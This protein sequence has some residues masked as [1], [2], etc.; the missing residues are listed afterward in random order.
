[1]IISEN[2]LREW[3]DLD[4]DTEGLVEVLNMAGLEVDSMEAAGPALDGVVVGR[5]I[6]V[7]EHPKADRLRVCHMDAGGTDTMS[8]VCGAPNAKINLLAPVALPGARLPGGQA[9]QNSTIRGVKSEGMLCSASELA[10]G[11]QSGGLLEL[12]SN[13]R[14]GQTL[15]DY[16]ALGDR[17]IN[18]DLT[19]NRGDCLSILGIAREIAVLTGS[20]LRGKSL[21]EV[22][23]ENDEGVV[24]AVESPAGCPR[25]VGRVI[26]G[27]DRAARTPCWMSERLRRC[28]VRP[29]SPVVDVTN[30]VMLEIGQPMHAFDKDRLRGRIVV[31]QALD[32]ESITLLDGSTHALSSDTLVIADGA[33]AIAIA[34]VMGG[35]H[36]AISDDTDSIVLEA[37]FFSPHKI[38]GHARRYG[39][40]TDSSHRF[41]RGVD[42]S[43][44]RVASHYA[45]SLLVNITGGTPGPVIEVVDKSHLPGRR[46]VAVRHRRIENLLGV[47]ISPRDIESV[48]NRVSARVDS[49][50]SGWLV[51]PPSYRFDIELECDLIE[52]VARARGYDR[53]PDRPPVMKIDHVSAREEDL[54]PLRLKSTLV[55]R[56]YR[57]V[58]TY[59]FV[60]PV[61]Q[62]RLHPVPGRGIE[63][64]NPLAP[65]L[66]VMRVSLWPGLMQVMMDNINRQHRRIRLFEIGKTFHLRQNKI[67]ET[68]RLSGIVTG[69]AWPEQW[70]QD[71]RQ[72]DF[73][74]V[75]SDLEALFAL[76]QT[77]NDFSFGR[78]EDPGLHPGQSA[79]IWRESE[80]V[81]RVGRLH[82]E[83]QHALELVQTVYLFELEMTVLTQGI[84][85]QYRGISRF[86][87]IRRDLAVMVDESVTAK[88]LLKLI[89]DTAG[90]Y[91]KNLELFDVYRR[92]DI[93]SKRKSMAFGLTL[94]ASSRTLRDSEVE[95][96]VNRTLDEL[97]SRYGAELRT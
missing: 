18:I 55:N 25:Y 38:V 67:V 82:P 31:R 48:L 87:A 21:P 37:A 71:N 93:D 58:V 34:G 27:M 81:G 29:I 78:S 95:S 23:A 61:L 97:R 39:L 44:P 15:Y 73:F 88:D 64:K 47:K 22:A 57:E 68:E 91:L 60:D 40:H 10:L 11:D 54:D 13:A 19:P 90:E 51:T 14:P 79:E 1:M 4:L 50:A 89:A 56:D 17:I 62:Q 74:D 41:E 52:E 96:I 20:V 16:L 80:L 94:Q 3:V 46:P 30:Y 43:L 70:G 26:E 7:N 86:P 24:I 2:W 76:T 65:N 75:K 35:E 69:N 83:H 85:P 66:S 9:V 77:E 59:S 53:I 49:S 5:I 72:A 28:G 42:P 45:T 32:D 36:S 63:L 8:I 6:A 84:M 33:G 92:E 12:D